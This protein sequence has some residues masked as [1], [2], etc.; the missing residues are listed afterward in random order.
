MIFFNTNKI[1]TIRELEKRYNIKF[2]DGKFPFGESDRCCCSDEYISDF[3][4]HRMLYH[5]MSRKE[6]LKELDEFIKDIKENH[7]QQ[8]EQ[9]K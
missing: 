4:S 2:I 6:T 7:K 8:L 9:L 1:P 5:K 3:I